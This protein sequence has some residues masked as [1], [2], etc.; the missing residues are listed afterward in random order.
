MG[1]IGLNLLGILLWRFGKLFHERWLLWLYVMSVLGPQIGN[2]VGWATTE[3]G[4]Q[5]WVVYGL[6]RTAEGVSKS[7]GAEQILGSLILFT[8]IYILLFALFIMHGAIYVVLKTEGEL[9]DLM[10]SWVNNTIIFFVI[11]YAT[12]MMATLLHLPWQDK[13][14][15][16]E[17][18]I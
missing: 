16:H 14:G 10:R 3:I 18:L 7:V 9:H 15:P 11:C 6:M 13:T 12:T 5:P 2:Q 8:L 4:R 17:L 1:L